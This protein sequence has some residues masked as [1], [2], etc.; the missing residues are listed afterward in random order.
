MH[1]QFEIER[2]SMNSNVVDYS[3]VKH[4]SFSIRIIFWH[5]HSNFIVQSLHMITFIVYVHD[6]SPYFTFSCLHTDI[7]S[8]T[9]EY[10]LHD[11]LFNVK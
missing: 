2:N 6:E 5:L 4:F 7:K 1:L 3:I 10:I 9:D 11:A 8:R